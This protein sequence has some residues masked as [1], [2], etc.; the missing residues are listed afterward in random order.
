MGKDIYH[1]RLSTYNNM[2]LKINTKYV[3]NA[4]SMDELRSFLNRKSLSADYLYNNQSEYIQ[5]LRCYPFWVQQFYEYSASRGKFPI[6]PFSAKEVGVIGIKVLQQRAPILL[7]S[8][9]ISRKYNNFMDYEPY[10]QIYVYIPYIGFQKLDISKVMGKTINFYGQVDFDNGI[11]TV[12]LIVDDT[13]IQSWETLIG[14][15]VTLNRTNNSDWARNMYLWGIKSLTGTG[16][17]MVSPN[18][19][20]KSVKGGGDVA[21]GFIGANQH[22]VYNGEIGTGVNKLYNPNSFYLVIEREKPVEEYLEDNTGNNT[23]ASLHGFPLQ[24]CKWLSTLSGYTEV[25]EIH[26]DGF[27]S[28]TENEKSE[29]VSLLRTGVIL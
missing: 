15:E 7:A 21:T 27:N 3:I 2:D 28:A 22:H 17:L 18:A 20:G 29:I 24:Q 6:G 16:A 4:D 1:S 8:A 9:T 11:L 5:S 12:W 14:I 25:G 19:T 10:T 26:L 23:F 13:M